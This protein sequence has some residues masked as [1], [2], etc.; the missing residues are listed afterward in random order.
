[1]YKYSLDNGGMIAIKRHIPAGE[2]YRMHWHDYIELE[3][4]L[5]GEA[6]HIY[7]SSIYSLKAHDAYIVTHHD[8]HAFRAIRDVELIN[9]G[10][11]INLID[12]K[13]SDSLLY[14]SN[15][16]LCCTLKENQAE[17]LSACCEHLIEAGQADDKYSLLA[18]KHI[19]SQILIEILRNC[20]ENEPRAHTLS[21]MAIEYIH[22]NFKEELS[23][24]ILADRLSVTPNYLGRIFLRDIGVSFNTYLNQIRL[25]Y[26]CNMLVYSQ[27]SV[28]EIIEMSGY[29]SVEY[30]F[31][32]FKKQ[33]GMTPLEFRKANCHKGAESFSAEQKHTN[34]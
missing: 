6:E 12:K 19:I 28:K 1:M 30:F 3:F 14:S 26:T 20:T 24:S 34:K 18:S 33:Y 15:Q 23:L 22:S 9:I 29:S 31:Y 17:Y 16:N 4:V 27:M 5:S 25:R 10:F 21:Q 11:D 13:L 32:I 2:I 7:N 8:L